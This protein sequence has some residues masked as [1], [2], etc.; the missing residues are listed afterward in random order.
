MLSGF[1][2]RRFCVASVTLTAKSS[3]DFAARQPLA[4]DMVE[5]Y[6]SFQ[7]LARCVKIE[8]F[9]MLLFFRIGP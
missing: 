4:D 6:S 3:S 2:N 5:H 7:G 9:N 1:P 8:Q